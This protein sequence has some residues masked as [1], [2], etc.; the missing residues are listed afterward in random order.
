[1]SVPPVNTPSLNAPSLMGLSD[2]EKLPQRETVAEKSIIDTYCDELP[3]FLKNAFEQC[4]NDPDFIE[5]INAPGEKKLLG[6][7]L[8]TFCNILSERTTV[9]IT[10]IA[11]MKYR[12]MVK[13]VLKIEIP[14]DLLNVFVPPSFSFSRLEFLRYCITHK[15]M[16]Q[17]E[18][19]VF[20]FG[21]VL[22]SSL[23]FTLPFQHNDVDIL[24]TIDLKKGQQEKCFIAEFEEVLVSFFLKSFHTS[25][26][27][28][29]AALF[30]RMQVDRTP[31]DILRAL[32]LRYSDKEL[33]KL[34]FQKL[35]YFQGGKDGALFTLGCYS[36]MDADLECL[37]RA[38]S[39]FK[40]AF[41]A[42]KNLPYI[43]RAEEIVVPITQAFRFNI[44]L[45]QVDL[46]F[47]H[48]KEEVQAAQSI[49][50]SILE[51]ASRRSSLV[52]FRPNVF[53][54]TMLRLALGR[55][56][57]ETSFTSLFS[58]FSS[59]TSA[60]FDM[61]DYVKKHN[62]GKDPFLIIVVMWN[63]YV[64][65]KA[66]FQ[67]HKSPLSSKNLAFC[68]EKIGDV[69]GVKQE[70]KVALSQ[71]DSNENETSSSGIS[72][73]SCDHLIVV[74]PSLFHALASD[75][76]DPFALIHHKQKTYGFCLEGTK[77][78][79]FA[80]WFQLDTDVRDG[81]LKCFLDVLGLHKRK[82]GLL[83][84]KEPPSFQQLPKTSLEYLL[85]LSQNALCDHLR[86]CKRI[87]IYRIEE[88]KLAIFSWK[89]EEK[90]Q[91]LRACL[92]NPSLNKALLTFIFEELQNHK[93]KSWV[94]KTL[95][96][97][98]E[99]LFGIDP[100]NY[101]ESFLK[102]M[103]ELD[104]PVEL[105]ILGFEGVISHLKLFVH[106]KLPFFD[107]LFRKAE[108]IIPSSQILEG[109]NACQKAIKTIDFASL[110]SSFVE[111]EYQ[112]FVTN[113]LQPIQAENDVHALR[114]C[115][116]K[117][118]KNKKKLKEIDY[119][120]HLIVLVEKWPS[121]LEL[122]RSIYHK[123]YEIAIRKLAASCDE[124]HCKK[125]I[126]LAISHMQKENVDQVGVL[127]GLWEK[128]SHPD[129]LSSHLLEK[130][131]TYPCGVEKQLQ[132][133]EYTELFDHGA[134]AP[135]VREKQIQ[136]Q[137]HVWSQKM[138]SH[139]N[140]LSY[141]N[142]LNDLHGFLREASLSLHQVLRD[143]CD[144]VYPCFLNWI[145]R[146]SEGL[147]MEEK[148]RAILSDSIFL[149]SELLKIQLE[150]GNKQA[151][152][153]NLALI[154]LQSEPLRN[155]AY[156]YLSSLARAKLSKE[157]K[158][159]YDRLLMECIKLACRLKNDEKALHY[160]RQ[161]PKGS[162]N[163]DFQFVQAIAPLV[164]KIVTS[165]SLGMSHDGYTHALQIN[166]E[167]IDLLW[168]RGQEAI[169]HC[170]ESVNRHAFFAA[171]SFACTSQERLD[172]LLQK[173][174]TSKI[175]DNCTHSSLFINSLLDK[176]ANCLLLAEE[177]KCHLS[178]CL[179]YGP[180][181]VEFLKILS[182]KV[183]KLNANPC[184][185]ANIQHYAKLLCEDDQNFPHF[186][187]QALQK[188][189]IEGCK[190]I[191]SSL[192]PYLLV[193]GAEGL[194]KWL[195]NLRKYILPEGDCPL[196]AFPSIPCEG[197]L[198]EAVKKL[199]PEVTFNLKTAVGD[200]NLTQSLEPESF[201]V[202]RSFTNRECPAPLQSDS[203]S[204]SC[205]NLASRT[206]VS[207][208]NKDFVA[209]CHECQYF[210]P[211][212]AEKEWF[213][214]IFKILINT[215]LQ[216]RLNVNEIIDSKIVTH[217]FLWDV[218]GKATFYKELV[219]GLS[220]CIR[221]SISPHIHAGA[222]TGYRY[223]D[224]V[225]IFD[226]VLRNMNQMS[227]TESVANKR[228][229]IMRDKENVLHELIDLYIFSRIAE[230]QPLDFAKNTL[231]IKWT[232]IFGQ[233]QKSVAESAISAMVAS[234]WTHMQQQH[235][236][237]KGGAIIP[238]PKEIAS[239]IWAMMYQGL[240]FLEIVYMLQK[241]EMASP[242]VLSS[243]A[244]QCQTMLKTSAKIGC[245][246]LSSLT[247][248]SKMVMLLQ[249]IQENENNLIPHLKALNELAQSEEGFPLRQEFLKSL[250]FI[251]HCLD[252]KAK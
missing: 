20:V 25:I 139:P 142:I 226:L 180:P 155:L 185:K 251:L 126:Q 178:Q 165:L 199:H 52:D 179:I 196:I 12:E 117:I 184:G 149:S 76:C 190:R 119:C 68:L 70:C 207:R 157:Q 111:T 50:Q 69:L 5:L 57:E 130:L 173:F 219:F 189:W 49:N 101:Q 45:H 91:C 208:F 30:E 21:S 98:D 33:C 97:F 4:R 9:A 56:V 35:V 206:A 167:L 145:D 62:A 209:D 72:E 211:L 18:L 168:E 212:A 19:G 54:K 204:R 41:H 213:K 236:K 146:F 137:L 74:I 94:L 65:E 123:L 232:I 181:H 243:F 88:L 170:L 2:H 160:V 193:K 85:S 147:G 58:V 115:F 107:R 174:I 150:M 87:G 229:F 75:Q 210:Y 27:Q 214:R 100:G 53:P 242:I 187:S 29:L 92:D 64:L 61:F 11:Y 96:S 22:F 194:H 152:H 113:L 134:I 241:D 153:L 198:L 176:L 89:E 51:L 222:I 144:V 191:F 95:F 148:C 84:E 151:Q 48:I 133:Y 28:S 200:A 39:E 103:E 124:D 47:F 99:R 177:V 197:D 159:L 1:M 66:S 233:Y 24:L 77:E 227:S 223:Q 38:D 6:S 112:T 250:A 225:S 228:L 105:F 221:Q 43:T 141:E 36:R 230:G 86:T 252:N 164:K 192:E 114:E 186:D 136:F 175:E 14:Y 172:Q 26:F 13:D 10:P 110:K 122:D 82:I 128:A 17:Y 135:L 238:D 7:I 83:H 132:L 220:H 116:V 158:N 32:I 246:A 102:V 93:N 60:V 131:L 73:V 240:S 202:G 182:E 239:D 140:A 162:Q 201:A 23:H 108:Q 80:A 161:M 121:G 104:L 120:H 249:S 205:A 125:L 129:K 78:D 169:N 79:A 44:P 3:E 216:H 245:A 31:Q 188:R 166:A 154:F 71:V 138:A 237:L 156:G 247:A 90:D 15:L 55:F 143:F 163:L 203:N 42:L 183:S 8:K 46:S 195:V 231:T 34:F 217:I 16:T 235:H 215:A 234:F 171:I 40:I 248:E 59:Q 67:C 118:E 218:H 127:L 81:F 106:C 63:Y 244:N 224:Y 109:I 37:P